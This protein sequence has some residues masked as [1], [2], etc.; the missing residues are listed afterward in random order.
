M[1]RK[2]RVR[3][4]DDPIEVKPQRFTWKTVASFDNHGSALAEVARRDQGD[5]PV[6]IKRRGDRFE[7]RVGTPIR[8]TAAVEAAPAA[9]DAS[10]TE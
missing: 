3:N 9:E 1:G 10:V 2:R 5:R 6:K 4:E 7:V 8:K